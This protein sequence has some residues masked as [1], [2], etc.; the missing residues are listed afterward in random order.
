MKFADTDSHM[1]DVFRH[2]LRASRARYRL[3]LLLILLLATSGSA[4]VLRDFRSKE[5]THFTETPAHRFVENLAPTFP[6]PPSKDISAP[7]AAFESATTSFGPKWTFLGPHPIPNGQ[8][9]NRV[10]PVSGRVTAIAVHPT[11]PGIAYVGAAQG[12]LYRTLNGGTTWTQLM[13]NAATGTVGTPLAI[14]A[15]AIDPTNPTTVLVGTGEGNLSGD[16]FFGNGLYIITN[17]DSF[18]PIVNGPYNLRVTDNADVFTG[19][20][21]VSI[22]ID[23]A[24]H[25]Q[26][27][28]ATSSGVGGILPTTYSVLPARGLYRSTNAFAAIDNRGTRRTRS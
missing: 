7:A 26:I 18:S 23:P 11:D 14:G 4:Q 16:S 27:F 6:L 3:C 19:R 9:E 2:R 8:T 13:D 12:G 24:N 25:N 15:V 21:I 1:I 28:C 17:A 5:T 22:A 20:S 10:D